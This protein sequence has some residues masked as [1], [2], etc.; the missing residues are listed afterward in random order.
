VLLVKFESFEVP[1]AS[2]TSATPRSNLKVFVKYYDY[3]RFLSFTFISFRCQSPFFLL[4]SFF[5]WDSCTRESANASAPRRTAH[6]EQCVLVLKSAQ[7]SIRKFRI[8]RQ[9]PVSPLSQRWDWQ[10]VYACELIWALC[11]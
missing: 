10:V 4:L 9:M 3:F 8:A 11:L 6:R 1:S 2:T 7:D 5:G